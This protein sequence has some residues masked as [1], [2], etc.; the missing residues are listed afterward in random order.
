MSQILI[1]KYKTGVDFRR[2]GQVLPTL[3]VRTLSLFRTRLVMLKIASVT[4]V[5]FIYV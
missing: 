2:C 5:V 1:T 4:T 3:R